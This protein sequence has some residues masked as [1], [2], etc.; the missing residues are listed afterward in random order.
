MPD[1]LFAII[2]QI[3]DLYRS[4]IRSWILVTSWN[5]SLIDRFSR[6]LSMVRIDEI[7]RF[8]A[9]AD[10]RVLMM[11]AEQHDELER[12]L[13]FVR[14]FL[15][16][17]VLA[18]AAPRSA[19]ASK[20]RERPFSSANSRMMS[21]RGAIALDLE[22]QLV[23][24]LAA[25]LHDEGL[26]EPDGRRVL[27]GHVREVA[28]K[29]LL[30]LQHAVQMVPQLLRKQRL[31]AHGAEI[32]KGHARSGPLPAWAWPPRPKNIFSRS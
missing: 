27:D 26:E 14:V 25:L 9:R 2:Y 6:L 1:L 20:S 16:D 28:Q 12:L 4:M 5:A 31:A 23:L 15:H 22:V 19:P 11:D 24:V 29:H 21:T 13:E 10:L 3:S 18:S 30:V 17:R 32:E 8:L 7:V